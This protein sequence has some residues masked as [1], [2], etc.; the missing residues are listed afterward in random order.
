MAPGGRRPHLSLA[1]F[2]CHGNDLDAAGPPNAFSRDKGTGLAARCMIVRAWKTIH[3]WLHWKAY[4]KLWLKKGCFFTFSGEIPSYTFTLPQKKIVICPTDAS[5][6]H[7]FLQPQIQKLVLLELYF[8]RKI[9]TFYQYGLHS[10]IIYLPANLN[11]HMTPVLPREVNEIFIPLNRNNT[12]TYTTILRE[13]T[14]WWCSLEHNVQL[15]NQNRP[16]FI[17]AFSLHWYNHH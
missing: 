5:V 6:A 12:E 13:P 17:I 8:K 9:E 4:L 10:P 14:I 1:A 2:E 16:F 11:N 3:G 15:I 7:W